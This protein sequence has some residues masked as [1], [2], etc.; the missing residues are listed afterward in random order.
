MEI[1]FGRITEFSIGRSPAENQNQASPRN[2]AWVHVYCIF[3]N[4]KQHII[5]INW[6]R[7]SFKLF[8]RGRGELV[9]E[10]LLRRLAT[11][12]HPSCFEMHSPQL[13][14]DIAGQSAICTAVQLV[15]SDTLRRELQ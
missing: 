2:E 7:L 15:V 14:Q 3:H 10:F 4:M 6:F 5:S 1:L 11:R 12:V 13:F 9:G 8:F